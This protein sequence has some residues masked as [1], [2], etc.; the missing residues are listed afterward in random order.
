MVQASSC[1]HMQRLLL[2]ST[3]LT[4]LLLTNCHRLAQ[5]VV[6][7]QAAPAEESQAA[8]ER[9][10]SLRGCGALAAAD[11]GVLKRLVGVA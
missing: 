9:Q 2:G 5:V 11:K 1:G 4:S 3:R 8:A 6:M 10:I 7:N